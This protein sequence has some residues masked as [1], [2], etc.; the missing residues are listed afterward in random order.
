MSV[1]GE[2]REINI[3]PERAETVRGTEW[4]GVGKDGCEGRGF[5]STAACK[6]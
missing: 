3:E 1:W 6:T 4:G 5:F 2:E